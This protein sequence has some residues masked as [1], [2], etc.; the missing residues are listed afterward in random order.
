MPAPQSRTREGPDPGN[1]SFG[2]FVAVVV[3]DAAGSVDWFEGLTIDAAVE[4]EGGLT[5]SERNR[6]DETASGRAN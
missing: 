1:G 2:R 5:N 6:S 4:V 3:G